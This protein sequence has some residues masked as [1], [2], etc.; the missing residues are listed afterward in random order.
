MMPRTVRASRPVLY[1]MMAVW[2]AALLVVEGAAELA[3]NVT[4]GLDEN[5]T[6]ELGE[7]ATTAAVWMGPSAAAVEG[8]PHRDPRQAEPRDQRCALP[9]FIGTSS[10]EAADTVLESTRTVDRYLVKPAA[11]YENRVM[12]REKP[13]VANVLIRRRRPVPV[14]RIGLLPYYVQRMDFVDRGRRPLDG[15]AAVSMTADDVRRLLQRV[16][17]EGVI[18][19]GEGAAAGSNFD[20]KVL[21]L[22][23]SMGTYL[24]II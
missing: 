13:A 7:N 1:A 5:A 22:K 24:H 14:Q 18:A 10:G 9:S 23:G 20:S 3:E 6:S 4:S 16:Y 11:Y 8:N 12:Y 2:S 21:P 19:G 17:S 15:E